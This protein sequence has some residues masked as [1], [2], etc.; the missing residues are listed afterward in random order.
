MKNAWLIL[1]CLLLITPDKADAFNAGIVQGLWYDQEKV[2]A[3]EPI[4]IYAAVRNNTGADLIGTVSFFVNDK[5][6]EQADIRVLNGR[7]VESWADWKPKYGTSTI[8]ASL[9]KS[10]ISDSATDDSASTEV[11]STLAKDVLFIDHD[12]DGDS[13]GNA[14]DTDD[15]NDGL[16]DLEEITNGT[17]PLTFTKP[18]Q[19][20]ISTTTDSNQ[21]PVTDQPTRST[22][23]TGLEEFV[24]NHSLY[25]TL[26]TLTD[27]INQTADSLRSYQ[28][29][30]RASTEQSI[31][32]IDI[33]GSGF[34]S[35]T[36]SHI[37][38]DRGW[39]TKAW[40]TLYDGILTGIIFI[41]GYPAFVEVILL[42]L[43]L[44]IIYRLARHFG[45]RR[46]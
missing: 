18:T 35:I 20:I 19:L 24:D 12:T 37:D 10:E 33:S 3:G 36:R 21:T 42:I 14:T 25:N 28:D 1:L 46:G 29:K 22:V 26:N 15:D 9:T 7:I 13:I 30:R 11:T 32:N 45:R 39:F 4:R 2:F 31:S 8:V 17:D 5:R 44:Y 40:Q 16:S 43:M 38:D 6:I 23:S 34:G 27:T 41:L